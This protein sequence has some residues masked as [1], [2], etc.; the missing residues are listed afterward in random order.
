M[1]KFLPFIAAE[2]R[3]WPTKEHMGQI[4]QDAGFRV[5]VKRYTIQ[6]EGR[7]HISFEQYAGDIGAPS[8]EAQADCQADILGDIEKISVA[9][10]RAGVVHSFTVHDENE[11]VIGYFHHELPQNSQPLN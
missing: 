8:V 1:P 4:L 5:E 6:V 9:L 3:P 11:K 7:S 10:K 2:C